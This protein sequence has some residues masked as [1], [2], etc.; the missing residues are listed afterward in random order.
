MWLFRQSNSLLSTILHLPSAKN[1][2]YICHLPNTVT[3]YFICQTL[4]L[5]TPSAKNCHYI[6]HLPNTVTIY[7]ICQTLSL[8]IPCTVTAH[9]TCHWFSL[10]L[11]PA[12]YCHLPYTVTVISRNESVWQLLICKGTVSFSLHDATAPSPIFYYFLNLLVC[13]F[14]SNWLQFL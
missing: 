8:Y 12:I 2:H 7:F 10:Y 13:F 6:F 11:S 4:S 3:K 14:F 1:C 5:Y 9:A